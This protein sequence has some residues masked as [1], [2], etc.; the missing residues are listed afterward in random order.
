M[1]VHIMYTSFLNKHGVKN[2]GGVEKYIEDLGKIFTDVGCHVVI[3]QCAEQEDSDTYRGFTVKSVKGTSSEDIMQFIDKTEPDYNNDILI[4]ATD[5]MICKNRFRR[6]IAIQ[7]GVAWD[8]A[9]YV[10]ASLLGNYA[11]MFKNC[12]RSIRKFHRYRLCRELVCV[13]YNFINW[14]RTQV[15]G[16]DIILHCIPNYAEVPETPAVRDDKNLSVV[17]SRRLVEYRG[18]RLFADSMAEI[19]KKYPNLRVTVAGKGPEEQYMRSKLESFPHVEFTS[20]DAEDSIKFHSNHHIAVV[21][22]IN[23]EGTS[24]SLLE[25]MASGCAVVASNIGGMSNIII[26]SYNGLLINPLQSELVDAIEQLI[27]N[28]SLRKYLADKAYE[29]VKAGFSFEKWRDKWLKLITAQ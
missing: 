11:A 14:Y 12:L 3:Y 27:T 24:L 7:H 10:R 22:T 8:E 2:I 29:T 1:Y 21:P 20:Y 23:H 5:F 16:I 4:F 9:Q 18:S 15:K 26:D 17:F 6:C 13:D 19:L 28:S 25:A